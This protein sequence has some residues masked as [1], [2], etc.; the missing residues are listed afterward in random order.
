MVPGHPLCSRCVLDP[1]PI[2]LS[3]KKWGFS[4]LFLDALSSRQVTVEPLSSCL[5]PKA[6]CLSSRLGKNVLSTLGYRIVFKMKVFI[7]LKE[8]NCLWMALDQ[9]LW[10]FGRLWIPLEKEIWE[11][12][13]CLQILGDEPFG[14]LIFHFFF[15]LF[16]G[17]LFLRWSTSVSLQLSPGFPF[18]Y[19][20]FMLKKNYISSCSVGEWA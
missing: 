16:L 13:G 19:S 7:H 14:N 11:K 10:E 6:E 12:A 9:C 8:Y 15:F 3:W 18:S 4:L 20:N 5:H 1:D 17:D 2:L